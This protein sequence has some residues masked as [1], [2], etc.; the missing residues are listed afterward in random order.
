MA[1]LF[2]RISHLLISWTNRS[3]SEEKL[4]KPKQHPEAF[5]I[6]KIVTIQVPLLTATSSKF[7]DNL[8]KHCGPNVPHFN[9]CWFIWPWRPRNGLLRAPESSTCS[10]QIVSLQIRSKKLQGPRR[11]IFMVFYDA[12]KWFI[13]VAPMCGRIYGKPSQQWFRNTVI[14]HP[15]KD[16]RPGKLFLKFLKARSPYFVPGLSG[17][18]NLFLKTLQIPDRV[19]P[20]PQPNKSPEDAFGLNKLFPKCLK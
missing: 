19:I 15:N 12:E 20:A 7:N 3:S 6:G 16:V 9:A 8:D 4:E 5:F 2:L 14:L 11:F 10:T 17:R 18:F 13:L 1:H